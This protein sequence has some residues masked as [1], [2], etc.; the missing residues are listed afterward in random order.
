M[1]TVYLQK[2]RLRNRDRSSTIHP[3]E[4]DTAGRQASN[5][6]FTGEIAEKQIGPKKMRNVTTNMVSKVIFSFFEL[7]GVKKIF[8]KSISTCFFALPRI[9][10]HS[11]F[12]A[13]DR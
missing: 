8:S 13:A 6:A 5:I 4:K 12:S 11:F 7:G 10:V 2:S 1:P 9:V 3:Q